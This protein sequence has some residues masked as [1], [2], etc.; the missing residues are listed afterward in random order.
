MLSAINPN[1]SEEDGA[2]LDAWKDKDQPDFNPTPEEVAFLRAA[3][4]IQ[5]E[6]DLKAHVV[7]VQR[8]A[9]EVF[10]Y[11]CVI[12]FS[13]TQT[14]IA[15]LRGYEETLALAKSRPNA[16]L[17]DLG[18][19]LGTDARKAVLDGFP[20]AQMVTSDLFKDFWTLGYELF[21]DNKDTMPI[22]FLAGNVFDSSFLSLS[23]LDTPPSTTPLSEVSTLSELHG[24]LSALHTSYFFHL[25]SREQQ[26]EL[27]PLIAGLLLP[28]RGSII[29][30]HHLGAEEE[31]LGSKLGKWA[32]N[33][34]SWTALWERALARV[35]WT[36]KVDI[37]TELVKAPEVMSSV[38][39]GTHLLHWRVTLQ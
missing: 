27:A 13:F 35:G 38:G 6:Q 33:R 26:E 18:C 10:P 19:C 20:P 25:F 3:T 14:N 32:H 5:D 37:Y 7:A 1:V 28:E 8:K 21:N 36:G 24:R 22:T 15:R 17:L 34:E 31:G 39:I 4:G 30:G 29:F 16:L 2:I 9:A 11:P 12:H 23:P